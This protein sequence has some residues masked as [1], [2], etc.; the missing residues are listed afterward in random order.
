MSPWEE[1]REL[2]AFG[3]EATLELYRCV[4]AV[5]R[6]SNF[7]PPEGHQSWSVDAVIETAHDVF[8]DAHGP[9]RLV[10]LAVNAD[11]ERSFTRLLEQVVRNYLRDRARATARGRL[12]RRLRELLEHDVRFAFVPPGRP[13]ERNVMLTDGSAIGVWGGRTSD[14]VAAA[15]KV[16]DVAIVRWRPQT[17]RQPP[18]AEARSLLAV[19]EA[20]L[21]AAEASVRLP[22]LAHV[23]ALRFASGQAPVATPVDD[24]EPWLP[25]SEPAAEAAIAADIAATAEA[26]VS[27]LTPRERLALAY[28]D[29]PVR[30]LAD[31]T[32]L[33]KSAAAEMASRVREIIGQVLGHE[34]HREAIL[35]HARTLV[36]QRQPPQF[37]VP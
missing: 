29:L 26:L 6:A 28:L 15:Y 25:P 32:G 14:L 19:C 24:V 30:Q 21:R 22:D 20:V 9:Q 5:A 27:Q 35:V 10:A 8:A 12:I 13:G 16:T 31:V 18:L 1:V 23:I 11:S 7:P 36:T 2:G 17:R 33:G 37:T 4:R 3:T 34:E